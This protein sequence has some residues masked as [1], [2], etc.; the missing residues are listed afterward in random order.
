MD[1]IKEMKCCFIGHRNI[2]DAQTTYNRLVCELSSIVESLPLRTF[3]FGSRSDFND[4]CHTV[5]TEL[6]DAYP[7]IKRIMYSCKSECACLE[8]EREHTNQIFSKLLKK[9]IEFQGYEEDYKFPNYL[10]AGRASY[11]ERNKAMIDDSDICIFYFNEEYTRK[12]T[13]SGT[14]IAYDYAVRLSKKQNGKPKI[15]N[16]FADYNGLKI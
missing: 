12:N 1:E 9:Q 7:D 10:S 13:R 2:D 5:V 14:A 15:I 4:M 3:L 6:R 11:I 16:I 8:S